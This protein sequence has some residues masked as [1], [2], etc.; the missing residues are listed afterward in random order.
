M[1]FI[2]VSSVFFT[3]TMPAVKDMHRRACLLH[4]SGVGWIWMLIYGGYICSHSAGSVE[5]GV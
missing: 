5:V 4:A 3:H 1:V 2:A